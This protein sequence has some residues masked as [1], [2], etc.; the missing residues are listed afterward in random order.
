M[1]LDP[2]VFL[3]PA[4]TGV[5]PVELRMVVLWFFLDRL[6]SGPCRDIAVRYRLRDASPGVRFLFVGINRRSSALTDSLRRFLAPFLELSTLLGWSGAI[7][8]ADENAA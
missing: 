6:I 8:F 2:P 1:L 7:S 5:R 3:T 4:Q